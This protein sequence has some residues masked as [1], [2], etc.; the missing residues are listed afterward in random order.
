MVDIVVVPELQDL[1]LE[2]GKTGAAGEGAKWADRSRHGQNGKGKSAV[3][4]TLLEHNPGC[5]VRITRG[6]L[7]GLS[8][9]VRS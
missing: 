3:I 7:G 6:R 5:S 4:L 8:V 2:R 9:I 1:L